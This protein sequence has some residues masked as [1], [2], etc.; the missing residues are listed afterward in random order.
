MASRL[1]CHPGL[2]HLGGAPPGLALELASP[3]LPGHFLLLACLG[4]VARSLCGVAAGA[5]RAAMTQHF[6]LARN[7]ADISAK[8]GSQVVALAPSDNPC[9]R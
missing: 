5:T 2:I 6:A 9:H 7:A 4:S 3:L 1:N 8:E